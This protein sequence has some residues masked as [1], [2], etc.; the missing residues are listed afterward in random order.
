MYG[1]IHAIAS[2]LASPTA[3]YTC[4]LVLRLSP[5]QRQRNIFVVVMRGES[6]ETR[7]VYMSWEWLDKN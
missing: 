5:V 7:L 6:L 2:F 1:E 3:W 4:S